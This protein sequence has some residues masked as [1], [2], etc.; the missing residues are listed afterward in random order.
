MIGHVVDRVWP[1]VVGLSGGAGMLLS[2]G[3]LQRFGCAL[4]TGRMP[5]TPP[6]G[7]PNDVHIV[8]WA[9]RLGVE[10]AHSNLFWYAALPAD[11]AR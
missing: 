10:I 4:A 8:Q 2:R 5:S 9:Q 3:A 1:R 6:L 11:G 7:T